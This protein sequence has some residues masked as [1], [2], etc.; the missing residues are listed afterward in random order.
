MSAA[1]NINARR[2]NK[3]RHVVSNLLF[4]AHERGLGRLAQKDRDRP[5]IGNPNAHKKTGSPP[6][7]VSW[8]PWAGWRDGTD[9][10]RSRNFSSSCQ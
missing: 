3:E 2:P 1:A 10:T 6:C 9:V 4:R 8:L 7:F 5:D